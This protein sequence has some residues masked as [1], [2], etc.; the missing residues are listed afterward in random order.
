MMVNLPPDDGWQ[1]EAVDEM[2]LAVPDTTERIRRWSFVGIS[3]FM[4]LLS[5]ALLLRHAET[6]RDA[7]DETLPT[8][9]QLPPLERRLAVLKQEVEMAELSAGLRSGSQEER[10]RVYVLPKEPDTVRILALLDVLREAMQKKRML[11]SLE[12]I[13]VGEMVPETIKETS[14]VSRTISFD[15]TVSEEGM[16]TLLGL[17][18]LT[19]LLTVADTFPGK[20]KAELF[21]LVDERNP[22]YIVPVEQVLNADLFSYAKDP[23][24]YDDGLTKA[25]SSEEALAIL[26]QALTSPLL[27]DAKR[28]LG[29]DWG[30]LFARQKLWPLPFAMIQEA[31]TKRMKD[32]MIDL[33]VELKIY[34][35]GE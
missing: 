26:R 27:D 17:M 35:R 31:E 28:L 7:R 29:S 8:A 4:L 5:A 22:A 9:A 2:P 12:S 14:L 3:C 20:Q 11:R 24:P 33:H 19:G 1:L 13:D 16:M 30:T 18:R 6:I 23:R 21:S 10:L 25:I 32:D 34:G 15:A